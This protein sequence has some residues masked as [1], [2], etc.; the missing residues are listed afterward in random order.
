MGFRQVNEC[1][2]FPGFDLQVRQRLSFGGGSSVVSKQK[3][4]ER[5]RIVEQR[6]SKI[7]CALAIRVGNIATTIGG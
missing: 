4:G 2:V 1:S 7:E 3:R 6:S 5:K